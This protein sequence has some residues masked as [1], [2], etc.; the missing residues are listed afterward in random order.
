ME[1]EKTG[2][3]GNRIGGGEKSIKEV[4]IEDVVDVED[5]EEEYKDDGIEED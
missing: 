4:Q 3:K 1:E 2:K 5:E